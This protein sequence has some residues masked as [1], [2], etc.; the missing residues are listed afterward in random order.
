MVILI[1][2]NDNITMKN[3][4]IFKLVTFRGVIKGQY[5]LKYKN[6]LLMGIERAQSYYVSND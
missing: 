5:W 3:N 2:V 4:Y 6:M 1:I